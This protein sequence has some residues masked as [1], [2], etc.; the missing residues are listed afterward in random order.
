MTRKLLVTLLIAATLLAGCVQ[1]QR[2]T[3]ASDRAPA[4]AGT[5]SPPTVTDASNATPDK[6]LVYHWSGTLTGVSP[7]RAFASAPSIPG[8]P[9]PVKEDPFTI[10]P[11][12][13]HWSHTGRV[14]VH[15]YVR[16][17]IHDSQGN[18]VAHS[19]GAVTPG[20]VV[21]LQLQ[22]IDDPGGDWSSTTPGNYTLCYYLDG[23]NTYQDS[24]VVALR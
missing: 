5:S 3:P 13:H 24:E 20:Y 21:G 19:V 8:A 18:V 11:G 1:L 4:P 17:E 23:T 6:L 9:G 12:Y 22:G 15:G 14:D 16:F 10:P 2:E 7:S